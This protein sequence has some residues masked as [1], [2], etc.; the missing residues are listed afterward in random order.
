MYD[1]YLDLIEIDRRPMTYEYLTLLVHHHLMRLNHNNLDSFFGRAIQFTP[2]S[3]IKKF[4]DE[5]MGGLCYVLNAALNY[6]LKDLGF[7]SKLVSAKIY[8][9]HEKEFSFQNSTHAVVIV[10]LDQREYLIDVGW[11]NSFRTPLLISD[12]ITADSTGEYKIHQQGD[13]YELYEKIDN[14]YSKQYSFSQQPS[15]LKNITL[16]L[17]V[18]NSMYKT[19]LDDYLFYT[20]LQESGFIGLSGSKFTISSGSKRVIHL[21]T[22][23][24]ITEVLVN[25]FGV[26]REF[27]QTLDVEKFNC[28]IHVG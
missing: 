8:R 15:S 9:Y 10:E 14:E 2:E 28:L 11:G 24:E 13:E 21:K 20:K 5:Q 22:H 4:L 26:K 19:D 6:L 3:L 1:C 27:L 17:K 7:S 23:S 18:V 25:N 12:E 16:D